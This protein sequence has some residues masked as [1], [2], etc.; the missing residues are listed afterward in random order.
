[1][2][3]QRFTAEQWRAWLGEFEQS[4]LTVQQFC[5]SKGTTANTFYNWRRRLRE[6]SDSVSPDRSSSSAASFV[7]VKLATSQVE[8]E[9]VGGVI[10]RVANDR[11]SL[12]PLVELLQE[13][14]ARQ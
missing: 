9:L 13:L 12:R 8:F 10:A 3:R 11:E 7:S 1:M 14:G 2:S 5:D 4:E 6:S